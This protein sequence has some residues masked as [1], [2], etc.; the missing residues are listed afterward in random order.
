MSALTRETNIAAIIQSGPDA[1]SNLYDVGVQPPLDLFLQGGL[2]SL[3]QA[4]QLLT[5]VS[6]NIAEL[7]RG[8]NLTPGGFHQLDPFDF[9]RLRAKDVSVP[10]PE[11]KTTSK[12]YKTTTI[13]VPIPSAS[14]EGSL[15]LSFRVDYNWDVYILFLLWRNLYANPTTGAWRPSESTVD[16]IREMGG[17]VGI[18]KDW[19][20]LAQSSLPQI[21]SPLSN[22]G[23][24]SIRAPRHNLLKLIAATTR[25]EEPPKLP[26][27]GI[28]DGGPLED[29]A[30]PVATEAT[31]APSTIVWRFRG[32]YV[33]RV[34][35]VE[36][37]RG[38]SQPVTCRVELGYFQLEEPASG[39][40]GI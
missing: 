17:A 34:D 1:A 16:I 11:V 24:V 39:W 35:G 15:S 30:A 10:S 4:A 2:S 28:S 27:K 31:G 23:Y 14:P 33:K 13:S 22:L 40:L 3:G 25:S 38:D 12:S 26:T 32:V 36:F 5:S 8:G 37:T 18:P 7:I 19:I 6:T 9:F 21:P 29:F 20:D